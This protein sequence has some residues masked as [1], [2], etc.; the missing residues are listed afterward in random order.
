MLKYNLS[1]WER[2]TFFQPIDVAVIGSGIVG[3]AAALH[4]KQLDPK[5]QVAILERGPL[6]I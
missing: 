2:E 5:L 1:Y 6:P 3:L 4:L